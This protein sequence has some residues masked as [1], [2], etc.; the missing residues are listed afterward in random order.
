MNDKNQTDKFIEDNEMGFESDL[1]FNR[2]VQQFRM[3][4]KEF[5]KHPN[6]KYLRVQIISSGIAMYIIAAINLLLALL[7]MLDGKGVW[8]I[9][10]FVIIVV[11]GV[12][13]QLYQSRTAAVI[14]FIYNL[15]TMNLYRDIFSGSFYTILIGVAAIVFTVRFQNAWNAYLING[16]VPLIKR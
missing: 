16:D 10:D 8:R 15:C 14:F 11:L 6:I 12:F 7:Y 9:F 13:L 1:T 4:K 5:Y 2:P 3:S